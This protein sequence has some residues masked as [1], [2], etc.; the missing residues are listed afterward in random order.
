MRTEIETSDIFKGAYLLCS[1]GC[2]KQ[3]QMNEERQVTFVIEGD[4]IRQK[5]LLYRTGRASVNPL[6]LRETLNF[7]RDVIFEILRQENQGRRNTH[8][9]TRHGVA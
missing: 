9:K 1:G 4:E 7:L 2:L 5:D 8:G 3:P 6:Q